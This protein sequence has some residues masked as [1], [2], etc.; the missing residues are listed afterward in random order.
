LSY[1]YELQNALKKRGQ[2]ACG[3]PPLP[4]AVVLAKTAPSG[5]R[6]YVALPPG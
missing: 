1:S 6:V 2:S 4:V 3:F 5:R